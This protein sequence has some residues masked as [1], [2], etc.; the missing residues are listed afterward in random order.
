MNVAL[1]T[2][3]YSDFMRGVVERVAIVRAAQAIFLPF[4]VL[5]ELRAGFAAGDRQ[6]VNAANLQRFLASPRV[7]VL[8]ADEQTTHYYAQ[9]HREL[10]GQGSPIPTNDLW[11]AALVVQHDLVLCTSDRHFRQIPQLVTC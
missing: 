2:N 10:R 4:I 6:S 3:G 11:I 9:L 7:S 1:D 8:L 5:G